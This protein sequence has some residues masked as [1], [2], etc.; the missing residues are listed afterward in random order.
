M[1]LGTLFLLKEGLV[2]P[3]EERAIKLY[4][5]V[6]AIIKGQSQAKDF[7]HLLG[8]I[9]SCIEI[10]PN[11]RLYMR[12]IQLHLLSFWKPS[13]LDLVKIIP[14]TQH[15]IDHLQWCLNPNNVLK[16]KY[17]N[18]K[19][20]SVTVTTDASKT[21]YGGHMNSQIVQGEWSPE[22]REWHINL[23]EMEAV[24]LVSK[25]FRSQSE[26]SNYPNQVRQFNRGSIY[27]Q[28]RRNTVSPVMFQNMGNMELGNSKPNLHKSSSR[29]RQGQHFGRQTEQVQGNTHRM[30]LEQGHCTSDFSE[31]GLPNGRSVC[32]PS[33]QTNTSL[34]F[35][36]S[37]SECPGN[38][39]SDNFLGRHVCL[40]VPS[41]MPDS[42]SNST[43]AQVSLSDHSDS[44]QW[45]RRHWFTEILN[46][47]IACPSRLPVILDLLQQPKSKIR[48]PNPDIVNLTAWLLSTN[49]LKREVFLKKQRNYSV[50]PGEQE[51]R[52]TLC[53]N[54]RNSVA[55]VIQGKLIPITQL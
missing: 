51:Q 26:M 32:V 20:P 21:G 41:N 50:L 8:V 1:Y 12:P 4:K 17:I 3:T 23:L 36:D 38:R 45:P 28:T 48:H 18:Q 35:M 29:C 16:G 53:Q 25:T 10:I 2:K 54:S 33:E 46:L 13:S 37:R 15:L 14:V 42:Q 30:D 7:L 49:N 31:V 34:L 44:S 22:Q 5:G 24:F 9:A 55:G 6:K 11:A 19:E 40:G 47:L 43:H 39:C 52:R 27:K